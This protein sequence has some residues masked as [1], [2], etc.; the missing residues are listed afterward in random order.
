[1]PHFVLDCSTDILQTQTEQHI[2]QQVHQVAAASGLFVESDI[3]VRL[4]PFD[5]FFVGGKTQ[6]F[7]HLFC[8]IMQ[9]R[10][11]E[12]KAQLSRAVVEKLVV[13]FPDIENIAMN[14][15]E[16]EKATYCNRKSLL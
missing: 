6:S 10:T 15:A 3:K 4:N 2:L 1:M 13:L 5:T 16:F 7:I 12:Q 11:T 9:G 14:V 8:H